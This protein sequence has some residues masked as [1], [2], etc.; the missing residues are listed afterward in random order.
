MKIV[1]IACVSMKQTVPV[2]AGQLYISPLFKYGLQYA[3]SLQPDYIG[4]LSAK[5]GLLNLE[6]VTAPYDQTLVTA[7]TIELKQ[8]SN[9][10]LEQIKQRFNLETDE[11]IFLAG[12]KYRKY[13]IPHI[14]QWSAPLCTMGIGKQLQFLKNHA[15]NSNRV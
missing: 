15:I 2:P 12:S 13:L 3:K 11:F 7:K 1:F 4:I 10:V 6:T 5:H 14:K 9:I 8:W